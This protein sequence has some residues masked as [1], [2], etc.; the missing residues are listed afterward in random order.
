M[1]KGSKNHRFRLI[2]KHTFCGVYKG[3]AENYRLWRRVADYIEAAYDT[4]A[5]KRVYIAG[6]G[7]G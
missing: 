5:L 2:G 4:E 7:A 1:P 3:E 6:D